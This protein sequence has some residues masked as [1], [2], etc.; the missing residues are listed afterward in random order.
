MSIGFGLWIGHSVAY[1]AYAYPYPAP[2]PYATGYPYAYPYPYPY[3]YPVPYPVPYGSPASPGSV[4]AAPGVAGYG[5]VSFEITPA[6]AEVYVDGGYAGRVSD[7]GPSQQP[8]TLTPGVHRI[9]IRAPGYR[10]LEFNVA[11]TAGHVI[12]YQGTLQPGF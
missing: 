2:Y 11:I 5:G 9:E 10:P 4:S 3:A 12:P 7:F 8:L 6:D 1:P